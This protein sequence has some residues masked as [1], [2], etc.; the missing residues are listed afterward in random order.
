MAC[1]T[2]CPTPGSHRSWGECARAANV[3]VQ[4]LG[5]TSA[6]FGDEKRFTR[7]NEA[8]ASAVKDGLDPVDVSHS[9]VNRAYEEAST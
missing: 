2:G 1:R 9:A 7:E 3:A 4:W 8:Y 5:G 6:S